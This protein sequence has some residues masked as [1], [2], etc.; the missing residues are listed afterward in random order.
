[1]VRLVAFAWFA[2]VLVA[3]DLHA[4]FA[5]GVPITAF[6][7]DVQEI[8][9]V[10]LDGA[11]GVDVIVRQPNAI[12]WYRN[13]DGLGSFAGS[14]TLHVSLD[15]LDA[16]D[17]ADVDADGDL[18]L[19][20]A[21]RGADAIL[22]LRNE[23][24]GAFGSPEVVVE[25]N[26][27]VAGAIHLVDAFGSPEPELFYRSGGVVAL[28]N[29]GGSFGTTELVLTT[30]GF[31]FDFQVLDVDEDGDPDLAS[32]NGLNPTLI[33]LRNPGVEGEPWEPIES[34]SMGNPGGHPTQAL[35]V[36]GDGDL[37]MANAANHLMQW[38]RFPVVGSAPYSVGALVNGMTSSLHRRGWTARLGCG[39][40]ATMLWTDSIGEPVQW[41]TYDPTL[42]AF[43]PIS[44]LPDLPS[45]QAIH[46]GDVNGDGKEDLVLWHGDTLS[47]FANRI[48]APVLTIELT[49]FDTLCDS[50][51]AYT[52]QHATP[53]GGIWR[54]TGVESNVFTPDGPGT[55]E[56]SYCLA[57][58][59]SGC[60]VVAS[61]GLEVISAPTLNL[62]A[63]T[64]ELS[65]AE[66]TLVYEATPAGGTWGGIADANGV[67]DRSCVARPV[68]GAVEYQMNAVNG[69]ECV[70]YGA[71]IQSPACVVVSLGPDQA[72]CH[73]GDT[74]EVDVMR[75]MNG[76]MAM[77]GMDEVIYPSPV[78]AIGLFYPIHAPGT[79]E[80]IATAIA[81]NY[82]P[83][84]DTMVVE[85]LPLPE[86]TF[87]LG[88]ETML[89]G[90][91]LD[92]DGIG[93]PVGGVYLIDEDTMEVFAPIGY[94]VG[95]MVPIQYTYTDPVTGCSGTAV[96]SIIIDG[97]V[98][99][100]QLHS[101][102]ASTLRP[103]PAS[104]AVRF[105]SPTPGGLRILDGLG[106]VVQQGRV[107]E[108]VVTLDV[109]TLRPGTYWVEVTGPSW[110]WRERLIVAR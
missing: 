32:F 56:L 82:C 81:P 50:G 97:T 1:M 64:P 78:N 106:R 99:L 80:I 31:S 108:G 61:Q 37:D 55:F 24:A 104:A 10:D 34:Y 9:T 72:V 45:F 40:G 68:E 35:D 103:N 110:S 6:I 101:R 67:V 69:G 41:S 92:L 96:D 83:G 11:S 15:L 7:S 25:M 71:L 73:L 57:D 60:P 74:L 27:G 86:V 76:G 19:V 44:T 75:P 12:S 54:G 65:C 14:D 29:E 13:T 79:Y 52:L 77:E 88:V 102:S 46:S 89:N 26:G 62:L 94:A 28:P 20:V 93:E 43:A 42:G 63:G 107:P 84:H 70:A 53:T 98:G 105:Q 5:P 21:D 4:Q 51:D 49:P 109:S 91:V 47:W 39:P 3:I 95:T 23:G 8:R 59:V 33:M 2:T 48:S 38:W 90:Q 17:F 85:V 30:G 58:E 100:D 87:N 66:D 18:D 36:D 16:C 22:L